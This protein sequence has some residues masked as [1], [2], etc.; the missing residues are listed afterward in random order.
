[1]KNKLLRIAVAFAIGTGAFLCTEVSSSAQMT[2]KQVIEYV[3]KADK[4]GKGQQQIAAELLAKGVTEAQLYRIKD[5]YSTESSADGNKNTQKAKVNRNSRSTEDDEEYGDEELDDEYGSRKSGNSSMYQKDSR[6]GNQ[7]NQ[8]KTDEKKTK[9][10]EKDEL[11]NYLYDKYLL[12]P[13]LEK[14]DAAETFFMSELTVEE[15][16]PEIFGHE[17]F[18]DRRINFEPNENVA[19]PQDYKLGPDDEVI[20]DIWG[21]NEA[22]IRETIT[23]E[24]KINIDQIG[25]VYLSGL[26]IKEASE[27]IKKVLGSK[28][29]GIDGERPNTEVSVSLGQIRTIQVNVMGEVNTP[30]AYRLSPFSTV[31]TAIYRAGGVNDKGSLRNIKLVRGDKVVSQADIYEYIFSGNTSSDIRLQDG[32]VLIVPAYGNLVKIGGNVKRPMYYEMRDGESL[33]SLIEY[34]GG[35]KGNAYTSSITVLRKSGH[36]RSVASVS[37]ENSGSFALRN[38]DEV[39]VD[40]NLDRYTNLVEIK[41]SVFHPGAYELCPEISTVRQLVERAGGLMEDAF[42]NRAV[43]HREKEDL[44]YETVSV[45]LGDIM[46]GARPDISLKK[47]DLL[48]ISNKF[49]V[50]NRGTLTINGSV[51]NPGTFPFS[52]NTT[53]EDLILQAGGLLEGA[54]LSKVDISR[55]YVDP[56]GK[57][58]PD[59]LG[60]TYSF[61]IKDGLVVD[62]GE[63]FVLEPY[64]VVSVRKSPTYQTQ[65][66]VTV[67]GEVVFPGEYVLQSKSERLSSIIVRAGGLSKYAYLRGGLLTRKTSEEQLELNEVTE[68][69]SKKQKS[70]R[71][72]LDTES[73]LFKPTYNI[74]IDM[75]KAL[76]NPGSIDDIIL[77]EGDKITIPENSNVVSISGEVLYPNVVIY[78]PGKNLDYY[79]SQ[80]GGYTENSKRSRVYVIYMNG[81]VS[82]AGGAKF[83]P[84]CQI[85]VP[86]KRERREISATEIM[87]IGTSTASLATMV[88]S[89][90]NMFK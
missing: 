8:I 87:S 49:D 63:Q 28:Y 40:A 65:Q 52:S 77:M 55:R 61:S 48:V 22:S 18:R 45:P 19:T 13:T 60:E 57:E 35:F 15:E 56:Y 66:F 53:I 81:N 37:E 67:E 25:P 14:P 31:F 9:L 10:P 43:I 46:S 3:K 84:G 20:I 54:S 7:Q 1:M 12:D 23:P 70:V 62:G 24:G 90:I 80:A 41:G 59:K 36:E 17:I 27:K 83:E 85:V 79:I 50:E 5:Q 73:V 86:K 47:N 88:V 58:V 6:D 78:Q 30:G 89:L 82:R 34:A 69:L 39:R 38:G 11:A 76:A 44:S 75:E 29:S 21:Y 72:S 33:A 42:M 32:D 16:L 68:K 71:D 4:A 74:G 51:N 2:D 26:T 64:D